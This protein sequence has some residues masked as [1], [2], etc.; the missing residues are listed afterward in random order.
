MTGIGNNLPRSA[1]G[2]HVQ[3]LQNLQKTNRNEQASE[4]REATVGD[5]NDCPPETLYANYTNGTGSTVVLTLHFK[6]GEV[7][8]LH[9]LPGETFNSDWYESRHGELV[10]MEIGPDAPIPP[11][12][13]QD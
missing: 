13:T 9:L 7:R 1:M 6:D 3:N 8:K 11:E 5:N 4:V 2:K 12:Y 10:N